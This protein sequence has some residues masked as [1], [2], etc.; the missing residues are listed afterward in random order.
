MMVNHFDNINKTNNYLSAEIIAH[1]N[2]TTYTDGNPYPGDNGS[3][4]KIPV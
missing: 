4:K 1:K 3:I 2:S